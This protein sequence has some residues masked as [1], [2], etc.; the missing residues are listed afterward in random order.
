MPCMASD[1]NVLRALSAPPN[2]SSLPATEGIAMNPK[3]A[4]FRALHASADPLI[5]YN[6]WDAGS[7]VAVA[8]AGAKALATGS[9][10]IAAA[11]GFADGEK[12]DAELMLTTIA[13]IALA[14]ELPLTVDLES[15]YGSE[16]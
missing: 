16:P 13:R 6:I 7:A 9:W 10:S 1:P 3:A 5:L 15:G 8:K 12:I 4:T 2:P 14:T 11:N